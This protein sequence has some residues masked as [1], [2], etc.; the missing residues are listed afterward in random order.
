MQK[1]SKELD[2]LILITSSFMWSST[3]EVAEYPFCF[4]QI[5]FQADVSLISM[6]FTATYRSLIPR[7]EM[8][9]LPFVLMPP[10]FWFCCLRT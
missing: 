8:S 10:S 9:H 2:R 1:A 6:L 3:P 7:E 5:L 4:Q